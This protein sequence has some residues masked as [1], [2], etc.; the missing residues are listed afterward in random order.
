MLPVPRKTRRVRVIIQAEDG[1]R[2]G[3]AEIARSQENSVRL[4]VEAVV[5]VFNKPLFSKAH[6][7]LESMGNLT[8]REL[9]N[10]GAAAAFAELAS[11]TL[12]GC[13]GVAGV[14]MRFHGSWG[15]AVRVRLSAGGVRGDTGIPESR[16]DSPSGSSSF[17]TKCGRLRARF[18][19]SRPH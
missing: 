18:E 12:H 2:L 13:G 3:S 16:Q 7:T 14:R 17:S 4:T 6:P 15:F 10:L 19:A 9:L 1:G 8:R 5:R 11:F